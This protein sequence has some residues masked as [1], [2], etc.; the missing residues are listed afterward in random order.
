MRAYVLGVGRMGTAIAWAMDRLGFQVTGMDT[1]PDAA[2]NM[3]FKVNHEQSVDAA[4]NPVMG[5]PRNDFFIVKDAEDICKGIV[6]NGP[7]PDIVISSL[8]YH[9]TEVVGKWCVDNEV[10]YCDL[11]G[12][13]D[14]SQNINDYAKANPIGHPPR[15]V[16]TDLGL[17]P[18]WV[19]ILAEEGVRKLHGEAENVKMMVGGL[20]DYPESINNPLRYAVTW[21]VDG[22]INEYRDDCLILEDGEIKTV[23]GMDGVEQ[24]EGEKFGK[25]EAFYTSGGAS[26]SIHAMQR[27]GIKNCSY[28]TIR[29]KGHGDMVR[30]LIRDCNLDDDTLNKIFLEGC[31]KANKDEVFIVAEVSGGNKT[32]RQEKV[33]RSD[34]RFSAMQKA[35]AF[36][37]SSVAAIMAEG[38]LEGNKAQ[39]RDYW[40]QYSPCLSYEDVP[41]LEFNNNLIKLGISEDI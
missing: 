41:Y 11:G 24:I 10:R 38:K 40:E 17:A 28:K 29:Y 15:P 3:P 4:G 18:G 37:I 14:V 12:R 39:H 9:Q 23:R 16:F 34:E 1:N 19:N 25:M 22:L 35:T 26:H 36:S 20:P 30:F 33:I 2:N 32:W 5:A 13:V 8:P 6:A 27:R 21:S 7:R 31:G